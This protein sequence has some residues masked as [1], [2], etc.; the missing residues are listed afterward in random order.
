VGAGGGRQERSKKRN[1]SETSYRQ[2]NRHHDPRR[3]DPFATPLLKGTKL[4]QARKESHSEVHICV[5]P[6]VTPDGVTSGVYRPVGDGNADLTQV[7]ARMLQRRLTLKSQERMGSWKNNV[8]ELILHSLQI[9]NPRERC[10]TRYP[11]DD[12][13]QTGGELDPGAV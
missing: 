9:K 10:G 11:S 1:T 3:H 12:P 2:G 7:I 4:K 5:T 6:G 13:F 8:N